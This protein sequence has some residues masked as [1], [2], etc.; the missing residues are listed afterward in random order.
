MA[1]P[2][3]QVMGEG[4][5][6]RSPKKIFSA[7]RALFWSKN[8]RGGGGGGGGGRPPEPLPCI[9]HCSEKAYACIVKWEG[10]CIQPE[11]VRL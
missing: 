3:L 5:R 9:R 4:G 7:L 10:V 2:D 6:G 11:C 1:D 8:K